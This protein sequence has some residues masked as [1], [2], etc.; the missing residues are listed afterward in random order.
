[1]STV[2]SGAVTMKIISSTNST[3]MNGMTFGSNAGVNARDIALDLRT[4]PKAFTCMTRLLADR[5]S[6]EES[7]RCVR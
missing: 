5:A 4:P 7:V 3:S 2:G 6:A 1:M